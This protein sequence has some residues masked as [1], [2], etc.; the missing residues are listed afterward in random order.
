MF[1]CIIRIASQ[2]IFLCSP[3]ERSTRLTVVV[4]LEEGLDA[5]LLGE[6]HVLEVLQQ[7]RVDRALWKEE[8]RRSE[9]VT[10]RVTISL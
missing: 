5:L 10:K 8:K 1:W 7:F 4:E 3:A 9:A 6:R 2:S